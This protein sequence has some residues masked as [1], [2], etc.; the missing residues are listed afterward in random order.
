MSLQSLF[1]HLRGFRLLALRRERQQLVLLCERITPSA[2]CPLCGTLAHR[3]HSRY[4]RTVWDLPL[5]HAPVLLRLRVRKWYCD[6]PGCSRRIFTERLPLVTSPHGRFTFALRHLLS[7]LGRE[8]GG[9][10]GARSAAL[11][12][13][14]V[15]G[16][17]ILYLM[18][19]LPLAPFAPPQVIGLDD[20]AWKRR[21]RYG[22]MVVD[23]ERGKPIALL[24]ERS[25][26]T[27]ARWLKD[28]QT[29]KIVARDRSKEFA[30]AITTALPHAQQ[31]AD[32][33]H[34]AKNLTEQLD[35]VVAARWKALRRTLPPAELPADLVPTG[36]PEGLGHRSAGE[37]RYQQ[38]LALA[39][40]G[41][42]VKMIASRIGLSH[43]TIHRWLAQEHGPHGGPRKQRRSHLDWT[44]PYLRERWK[45]GERNGLVLWE[46]LKRQGY[47]GSLRSIYRRI[48]RWRAGPRSRIPSSAALALPPSPWEDLTPGRVIGWIIARPETLHPEDQARLEQLCELDRTLAQARALTQRWLGFIRAHSSE[49]LERWLKDMRASSIPAFVSFARSVG[50]D[51]AAIVAGLSLPCSTEPVEGHNNRLKVIKRQAYGQASLS[52]LQHRFLPAA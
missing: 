28:H 7:H 39:Q 20:W 9:A 17:A 45:A 10:P 16:R 34:L 26:E 14:H 13:L 37:E 11:L 8:H 52:Y 29:I 40:V 2:A 1:P 35:K 43:Q 47:Q 5:Q 22:A 19:T 12:G 30:A 38:V 3:I 31:V 4:E 25:Q 32:R 18:H 33:W 44:T 51:K 50:R 15:T 42:P 27:V 48:G 6:Q 23:L 41:I 24:A 46:E 36:L 49:G 21:Q